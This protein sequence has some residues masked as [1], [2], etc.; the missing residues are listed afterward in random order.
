MIIK[1]NNF[2]IATFKVYSRAYLKVLSFPSN[3]YL[4]KK[5]TIL[6][7]KFVFSLKPLMPVIK[8]LLFLRIIQKVLENICIS[9]LKYIYIYI[10]YLATEN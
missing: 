10:I 2:K 9:D 7:K 6:E 3:T 4:K 1:E 8:M 5:K